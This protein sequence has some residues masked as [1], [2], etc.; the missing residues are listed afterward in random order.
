MF[1][2]PPDG[3]L[4]KSVR[5]AFA[6][7]AQSWSTSSAAASCRAR[8]KKIPSQ[9]PALAKCFGS[10]SLVSNIVRIAPHYSNHFPAF[11]SLILVCIC[12]SGI[13]PP[14]HSQGI[15]H[16][17][18][19]PENILL[20]A[21]GT[22]R[23]SD[24]GVSLAFNVDASDASD[25][26]RAT[27][28]TAAFMAPE[29]TLGLFAADD[30]ASSLSAPADFSTR[31]CDVWA[32][33]VSLFNLVFGTVPFN[34]RTV[35]QMYEV[36]ARHPLVFPESRGVSVSPQLRHLLQLILDK[37]PQTR[38]TLAEIREHAWFTDNARLPSTD[39]TLSAPQLS[40]SDAS[41][42]QPAHNADS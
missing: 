24:F 19:K 26:V 5:L 7:S 18:I 17:D 12:E 38:A 21:D 36:I 8:N 1:F 2:L 10:S 14:V 42:H 35:L 30:V 23:I 41:L 11:V 27:E 9:S 16:R 37:N 6:L 20:A 33:G 40:E 4:T 29:M 32:A 34:A 28:G 15:A 22:I 25:R 3:I 39:V 13:H 31:Q